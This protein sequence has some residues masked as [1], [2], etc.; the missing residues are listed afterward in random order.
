MNTM[1]TQPTLTLGFV[2]VGK[3]LVAGFRVPNAV[4][5]VGS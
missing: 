3:A 4:V 5:E 1:I 2:L